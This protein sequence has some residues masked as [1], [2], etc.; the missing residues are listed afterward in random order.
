MCGAKQLPLAGAAVSTFSSPRPRVSKID[1]TLAGVDGWLL[2]FISIL[3]VAGPILTIRQIVITTRKLYPL[4][5]RYPMVQVSV[6]SDILLSAGMSVFAIY[7]G[8]L[9]MRRSPSAVETAKNYLL[10]RL[11][12]SF[13]GALLL[14]GTMLPH[15]NYLTLA[16]IAGTSILRT[17]LFV[18]V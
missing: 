15:P 5:S 11:A 13:V 17:S 4:F 2:L 6:G 8:I 16:R 1:P 7:V 3:V 9:L 10:T 14:F 18:F 12:F